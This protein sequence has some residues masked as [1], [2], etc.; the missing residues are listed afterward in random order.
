MKSGTNLILFLAGAFALIIAM[1]NI[2]AYTQYT[3]GLFIALFVAGLFLTF[4][5]AIRQ[6]QKMAK[7]QQQ[8]AQEK[9]TPTTSA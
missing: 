7:E 1:L 3:G 9:S 2:P 8:A 6:T 5:N 4:G